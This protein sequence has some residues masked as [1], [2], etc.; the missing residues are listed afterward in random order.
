MLGSC[1]AVTFL[2]IELCFG[3]KWLKFVSDPKYHPVWPKIFRCLESWRW[4]IFTNDICFTIRTLTFSNYV[5]IIL[6]KN[7]LGSPGEVNWKVKS[8]FGILIDH[9][10][11]KDCINSNKI[12]STAV[13]TVHDFW[14][15]QRKNLK[16]TNHS[17]ILNIWEN[18]G[19]LIKV[20]RLLRS[21][22]DP[23]SPKGAKVSSVFLGQEVQDTVSGYVTEHLR[24]S[25][26][27]LKNSTVFQSK[28]KDVCTHLPNI[29]SPLAPLW[30]LPALWFI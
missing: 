23:V 14:W 30:S 12:A 8:R 20:H 4:R 7:P 13:K 9:L 29:W 28:W 21:T 27:L 19:F 26:A 25:H 11:N 6:R 18:L 2:Y 1:S 22:V 5:K 15:I 10:P 16:I 17:L 3:S 24:V